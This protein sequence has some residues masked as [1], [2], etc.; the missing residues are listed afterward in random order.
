M[1]FG[2]RKEVYKMSDI[3]HKGKKRRFKLKWICG[4]FLRDKCFR[5]KNFL[6]RYTK[7]MCF[8][9][10]DLRKINERVE[11]TKHKEKKF[12]EFEVAAPIIFEGIEEMK[13]RIEVLEKE[14]E[15]CMNGIRD[16]YIA[17]ANG[18]EKLKEILF[19]KFGL[20]FVLNDK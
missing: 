14:K 10:E 20:P 11:T 17:D 18:D 6:E 16:I 7:D 3:E 19:G 4:E 15:F 12:E 2:L 8:S 9:K 1:I 5:F 13:E